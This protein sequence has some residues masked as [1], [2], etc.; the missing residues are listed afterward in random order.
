MNSRLLSEFNSSFTSWFDNGP[1]LILLFLV[2]IKCRPP[3]Y[4]QEIRIGP[5]EQL[6]TRVVCS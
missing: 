6:S 2:L 4:I 5:L 3:F 1:R